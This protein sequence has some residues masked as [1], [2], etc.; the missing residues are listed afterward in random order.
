MCARLVPTGMMTA[1]TGT[2][3]TKNAG[4]TVEITEKNFEKTVEEGIVF[5]DWWAAWCGPCRMFAP[6]FEKA[7]HKYPDITWGKVDT[8]AEQGLAGAFGIRSI[9]TLMIFRDGVLVFEQAGMVPA[10]ALDQLVEKVRALDMDEVRR[11]IAEHETKAK[12]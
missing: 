5:L 9:P 6:V 2:K 7:S 11:K 1:N 10:Q 8:D 3:P 4:G 12:R